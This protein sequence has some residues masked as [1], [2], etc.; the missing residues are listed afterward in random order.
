MKNIKWV[1]AHE[2]IDL[3]LRAANR[4]ADDINSKSNEFNLEIMTLPEYSN[5]YNDGVKVDKNGLLEAMEAGD[6]QMSQMFTTT[7]GKKHN[8]DMW[9][10]DMPFLFRDHDHATRVFEGEIGKKMLNEL[11]SESNVKGLAFTYS[12][13][14]RMLPSDRDVFSVEDLKGM[15][16]RVHEQ[17]PISSE[18]F[19][20]VGATPVPLT[21]EEIN[22]G[23][24]K[25]LIDAGESTY[26]RYYSLKQNE[27][28]PTINDTQHSLF[29]T[30]ILIGKNFWDSMDAETQ[31]IIQSA[32]LEAAETERHESIADI[33]RV[34]DQCKEDGINIIHMS[35][36][37]K[38]KFKQ[39]TD[40][41]YAKFDELFTPGLLKAIRAA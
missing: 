7:L 6:V 20:A 26:P 30:S 39:A 22:E 37:E 12:G 33:Q 5:K 21:L 28:L 32:A 1:I 3:F 24:E 27:A 19:E 10:L 31:E 8:K 34:A 4:F 17:S 2:P 23:V 18:T 41:M 40:Y 9:A 11:A 15:R 25:D 14:F 13:G 35:D 36:F 16:V 29:L 38:D